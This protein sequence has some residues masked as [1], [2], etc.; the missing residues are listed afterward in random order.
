M[1]QDE[2]SQIAE[3]EG[4]LASEFEHTI[5]VCMA[6]SCIS[7]H[8]DAVKTAL[9][10]EVKRR[11]LDKKCRIK[12]VGCMG[13]CAAG[14]L[15]SADKNEKMYQSVTAIDAS[16]ILDN[17]LEQKPVPPAIVPTP[18]CRSSAARR[19]SCWRIPAKSIRNAS[20][21][22]SP[23][24]VMRRCSRQ[25]RRCLRNRSSSRSRAAAC[26]DAGALASRPA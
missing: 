4:G 15:V 10:A 7:S 14:P 22:T 1:T 13:L 5:N 26:V 2:L 9:E 20:R 25:S 17:I 23:R 19:E 21:T 16:A 18:G 12:G 6:A 3:K 8:G 24:A 11:G